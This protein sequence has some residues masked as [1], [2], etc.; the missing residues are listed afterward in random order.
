MS[1]FFDFLIALFRPV[2]KIKAINQPMPMPEE[3][4][5]IPPQTTAPTDP[6]YV[7]QSAPIAVP[8]PVQAPPELLWDTH[9][10]SRHSIR[11][12][13]DE[14]NTT[15]YLK[16]VINACIEVESHCLNYKAPGV[17]T[18]HKNPGSTDW[19]ICQVN[20]YF[21]IGPYKDFPSV[22]YVM[23]NPEKVVRWMIKM[24]LEGH[25]NLWVSYTS[26]AY[27]KYMP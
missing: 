11:V 3:L 18:T 21:H 17:P 10:N 14:M 16:N 13:C 22:S 8:S 9:D 27:K 6:A 12:L 7:P 2:H 23:A 24:A 26:G 4:P 19:G 15:V 20:D 25:L 5:Q 1:A